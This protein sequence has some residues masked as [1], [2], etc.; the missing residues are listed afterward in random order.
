MRKLYSGFPTR[1]DTNWADTRNNHM[2]ASLEISDYGR[3]GFVLSM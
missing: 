2:M 3:R 1:S